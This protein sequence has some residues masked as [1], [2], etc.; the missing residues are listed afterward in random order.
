MKIDEQ[1][2]DFTQLRIGDVGRVG[3]K[4]RPLGK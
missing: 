2:L 4:T 3:G 1:V